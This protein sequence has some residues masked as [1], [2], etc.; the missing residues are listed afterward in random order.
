VLPALDEDLLPCLWEAAGGTVASGTFRARDA[1]YV[2]VV[3]AS[4][5][6]PGPFA[7]GKVITGLDAAAASPGAQVFHAGTAARDGGIVTSGGRVLTVVGGGRDFA[8]ARARAYE[9]VSRISFDGMH[10]RRDIGVR[11]LG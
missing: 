2:G 3:L 10:Y 4:G 1:R 5:G 7:A 9:A 11:A 6:Y 8:E